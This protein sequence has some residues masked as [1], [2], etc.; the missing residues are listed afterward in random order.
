MCQA[1]TPGI[2]SSAKTCSWYILYL[3]R[4]HHSVRGSYEQRQATGMLHIT[5]LHRSR[6]ADKREV[7]QLQRGRLALA[8]RRAARVHSPLAARP[9][10]LGDK[11]AA[12]PRMVAVSIKADPGSCQPASDIQYTRIKTHLPAS[13]GPTVTQ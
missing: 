7:H 13:Q 1:G 11:P 5:R 12:D 9:A 2:G 10:Q 3:R 8:Q 6:V 4:H